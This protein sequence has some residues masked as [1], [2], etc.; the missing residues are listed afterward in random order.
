MNGDN[1]DREKN[2]EKLQRYMIYYRE[3]KRLLNKKLKPDVIFILLF[4]AYIIVNTINIVR[5]KSNI[6]NIEINVNINILYFGIAVAVIFAA[7]FIL[8]IILWRIKEFH[9][10]ILFLSSVFYAVGL[11]AHKNL[12]MAYNITVIAVLFYIIYYCFQRKNGD[13]FYEFE[14]T[15]ET[16]DNIQ[17]DIISFRT[18]LILVSILVLAYTA[19]LSE[20]CIMRYRTFLS[21][22]FDFGIFAQMFENMAKTGLQITSVERNMQLSHFAV[23]FSPFYY[24]LL[25]FYMIFR[26]PESL[27]VMQ[28]AAVALGAFPLALI[29]K[30]FKL[31]NINILLIIIAYL[32][33]PAL[34]GGLFFDFHENKFLTVLILWLMY[35]I[36]SDKHENY[37]KYILIYIFAALILTVKEDSF[38]YVF[39]IAL[40]MIS[41]KKDGRFVKRN[42]ITGVILAG[43]SII[44]FMFSTFYLR[45]FGLGVMT[46]RY[47]LFLRMSEDGFL[48]M[49]LN[50]V[51]NPA[52]LL[53]SLLSVPEKLDFIFYMFIPLCFLPFVSKK[54]NFV[55]LI[56]PMIIMNLATDYIY[57]Y[58]VNFQYTYGVTALLFFLALK[59]LSKINIDFKHITKICVA[60]ACFSVI[61]FT[62]K[63]FNRIYYYNNIYFTRQEEFIEADDLLKQI[64]MDASVSANTFLVPHLIKRENVY[65]ADL[66]T[67]KYFDCG[68]DYLINDL[69]GID[70]A[71]YKKF[72]DKIKENGYKK[73]DEGVFIEIFKKVVEPLDAPKE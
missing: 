56:I 36:I 2:L 63:N 61:L 31:N 19:V 41:L 46:Y 13:E 16:E 21:S 65:M 37:K 6:Y 7:V 20:A 14:N 57:Q 68:T 12:D 15:A 50:V 45:A 47:Y 18:L 38:L 53:A 67:D 27:L 35:F 26:S 42:I 73:I 29:A 69:R 44:Y 39:C 58:D 25:P 28:S 1:F 34:N 40:Y 23:H 64:P 30:K 17:N 60:M 11:I 32:F 10:Y 52:L 33:Y 49:I 43:S 51:K 3:K 9:K 55:F 72:L 62:S 70:V 4:S 54:L 8:N 59:N 48:A 66:F 22:T 71:E 5:F 24:L